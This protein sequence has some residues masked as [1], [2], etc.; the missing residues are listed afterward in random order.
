MCGDLLKYDLHVD[1]CM[2]IKYAVCH[3]GFDQPNPF[4]TN[5]N[6][7]I[8]ALTPDNGA[9]EGCMARTVHQCELQAVILFFPAGLF[10]L[11]R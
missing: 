8:Y 4:L 1:P 10:Q 7:L 9:Y 5:K 3:C 11:L 6:Q 2:Y